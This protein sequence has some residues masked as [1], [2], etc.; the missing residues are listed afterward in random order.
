VL[1]SWVG[2]TSGAAIKFDKAP[3]W[4]ILR[5]DFGGDFGES[6]ICEITRLLRLCRFQKARPAR[7][8]VISGSANSLHSW[9]E[10]LSDHPAESHAMRNRGK[11]RLRFD[12]GLAIREAISCAK[13][14]RGIHSEANYH[15]IST[16]T[17]RC[18]QMPLPRPEGLP[19]FENPPLTEVVVSIQFPGPTSY[20]DVYAGEIWSLFKN[21]FPTVQEMLPLPPN[22]EVFGGP[23]VPG[24]KLNIGLVT[25]PIRK[26][27]WFLSLDN[28]ELIQFQPDR[29]IHNWRKVKKENN[30]YGHFEEII[31]KYAI[32]LARLD[33]HFQKK[34]WGPLVPNQCEVTYVNQMPLVDENGAEIPL[35]FYFRNIDPS[36]VGA[37]SDFAFNLRT[38]FLDEKQQPIGRLYI[39]CSTGIDDE[40]KPLIGLNLTMRG[41]PAEPSCAS[42]LKLLEAGRTQI[43]KTFVKITS[44]AAH[45]KWGRTK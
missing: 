3:P 26:R 35:S 15:Y 11:L 16:S 28:T 32:E 18:A 13:K 24:L 41:A 1:L 39:E 44:D 31:E 20:S 14:I 4:R 34:S 19:D 25:G 45:K 17:L 8:F 36:S 22:F 10:S 21:D 37:V 2:P 30:T 27:Y 29:F 33:E 40:G 42:A 5:V 6:W 43:D 9:P 38:P 7:A 12:E 23:E